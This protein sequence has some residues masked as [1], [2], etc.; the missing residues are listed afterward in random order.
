M[1]QEEAAIS[2]QAHYFEQRYLYAFASQAEV[3]QHVRTQAIR[4]EKTADRINA[5]LAAWSAVRPRVMQV[6]QAEAGLAD[7]I[8][9]GPIPEGHK[10]RLDQIAADPLF[11]KTFAGATFGVVEIDKVVAAQRTVNLGYVGRLLE[12]LPEHPPMADLIELCL[13]SNRVMDPIQ[14]L[15]V[16][17]SVHAFSSPNSDVRFLGSFFKDL[18]PDD[19][20]YAEAGL[21]AAAIIVFVGYGSPAINV[22]QVGNRVVLG[23]GFH[24]VYA[25]RSHGVTE[26]PVVVRA[27]Q[28]P[29]I[30]FPQEIAGI[31]R[32]YLLGSSRPTLIKDFLD[33]DFTTQLRVQ[34]RL[35]TVTV[36][37]AANQY[38]VPA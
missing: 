16:G 24:R 35:K 22:Y 10:A 17:P 27:V 25:L 18:Q 30:E 11:Q 28:N 38:D 14:H 20:R 9:V 26:I 23:N 37:V 13:S 4:E 32:E 15:E 8:R 12:K 6:V 3:Y 33:E 21:P 29:S 2:Q 1:A 31:P 19:L 5:I 36:Q 7:T 34:E